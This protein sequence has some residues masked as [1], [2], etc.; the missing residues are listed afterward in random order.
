MNAWNDSTAFPH[1]RFERTASCEDSEGR[2][3]N[4]CLIVTF[5]GHLAK[6]NF[7]NIGR[8]VRFYLSHISFEMHQANEAPIYPF[9]L[10]FQTHAAQSE[11]SKARGARRPSVL[12]C[13]INGINNAKRTHCRMQRRIQ[14]TAL[15]GTG[16][17]GLP[18]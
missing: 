13:H 10:C 17:R 18:M 8:Q 16:A 1:S 4:I 11:S 15:Y 7:H 14:S 9:Q 3:R 6:L 2:E 5:Q 12:Q